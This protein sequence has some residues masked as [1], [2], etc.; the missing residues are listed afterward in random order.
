MKTEITPHPP[1][2]ITTN[3][4]NIICSHECD[5]VQYVRKQYITI[6]EIKNKKIRK[7]YLYLDR[8]FVKG[9]LRNKI[10]PPPVSNRNFKLKK[11]KIKKN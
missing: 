7:V 3:P 6:M 1:P 5:A 9:A 4:N 11:K 10:T 2:I 8:L